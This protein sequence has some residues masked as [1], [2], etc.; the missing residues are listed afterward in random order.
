MIPHALKAGLKAWLLKA[1]DISIVQH[2]HV[3]ALFLTIDLCYLHDCLQVVENHYGHFAMKDLSA[4][5]GFEGSEI[6]LNIPEEGETK[7]GWNITPIT[8]P[9]VSL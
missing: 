4:K 5:V 9:V 8:Y 6:T 1:R 2:I 7:G 3:H